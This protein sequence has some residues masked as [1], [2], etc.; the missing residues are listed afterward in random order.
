METYK[1]L[2]GQIQEL[3]DDYN[4]DEEQLFAELKELEQKNKESI[5]RYKEAKINA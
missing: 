5:R 3:D 1:R 2:Q 4:K